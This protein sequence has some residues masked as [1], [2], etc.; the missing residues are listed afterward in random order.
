ML[1]LYIIKLLKFLN[2]MKI[3]FSAVFNLDSTNVSQADGFR[4][5]GCEVIEFNYREIS[6][7]YGDY[8]RDRQLI[9]L[10][11]IEKPDAVVFSKCN[12]IMSWVVDECNK[13]CKTVLWY[14]DTMNANYNDMLIEKI[15]KCDLIFCSIWDSYVAAKQLGGDKVYFLQEGYDHLCNYPIESQYLYDV[16]FIGNLRNKRF[17]YYQAIMFK[18]IQNAYGKEHSL[19]VSQTK[20]NLN[21]TEGGTSDRTYKVL[22]SKGF[23]LTE[24][25]T[26]MENDFTV[27]RDLDIFTNI[28]ELKS[29]IDYYLQHEDERLKIAE[30]GYNTVKKF[31]RINWAKIILE[32]L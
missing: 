24:P 20:I 21:F 31:D 9:E 29:K 13:I 3:V 7:K 6:A 23:M 26:N 30:H 17:D 4:K 12:E 16:S 15:K 10:C 11:K 28:D 19:A 22:A 1:I 32:K 2:K 5:N 27:G 25:W 8:E 14:M 18:L